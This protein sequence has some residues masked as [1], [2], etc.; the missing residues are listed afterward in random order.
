MKKT[1]LLVVSLL[2]VTWLQAQVTQTANV[3]TAGTLSTVASGYLTTVTNLTVTGTIDAR[4]FKTMRDEMTA[5]TE[6]DL[7]SVAIEE[8][9]GADGTVGEVTAYQANEIPAKALESKSGLTSFIFPSSITSIGSNSFY[10]CS[11]LAM[12]LII[13]TSV[14][15]I[16]DAAFSSC[17]TLRGNLTLPPNLASLGSDAFYYCLGLCG[18]LT[19][20][21]TL[22][23][24]NA[25]TFKYCFNLSGDLTLPSSITHIHDGAFQDCQRLTLASEI[26]PS[27]TYIGV[28]AFSNC[29][30]SFNVND[31]NPN[32]SSLDGIL[33]N[34][35]QTTLMQ[36]LV[37]KTGS[38]TIPSTVTIINPDAFRACSGLTGNL[39]IPST[40]TSIGEGAFYGCSGLTGT[41]SIPSTITS[42][43]K[44]AFRECS[45]FTGDLT[46]PSTVTSIGTWAFL[47]CSGLT[48]TLTIP[49][50]VQNIGWLAFS[51]CSGLT[52][53]HALSQVPIDMKYSGSVFGDIN[54]TSCIL[55]VPS[56]S[57]QAYEA[58]VKWSDFEN[59]VDA[60]PAV[61]QTTGATSLIASG[62][63]ANWNSV[64]YASKYFLDVA[65]DE[66]FTN[67]V[68][69]YDNLDVSDNVTA[70]VMGLTA[71]TAY[72]FRVRAQNPLGVSANSNVTMATLKSAQTI[73]FGALSEKTYGDAD[74]EL[75][76]SASSSLAISYS[77]SDT[78]VATIVSGR[79]HIV[80]AGTCTIY[81]NQA[82]DDN[83]DAA[84]QKSQTLTI[85]KATLTATADDNT[86]KAGEENPVFT[87]KLS[88]FV[89]GDDESDITELPKVSC[90]ADENSA[91]G[92]YPITVSGGSADNY[93]FTYA[94][95][96]LKVESTTAINS[97]DKIEFKV[98]PNPF[99]SRL[100]VSSSENIKRIVV[101]N[102]TG[103]PL[104]V[105]IQQNTNYEWV[106][107]TSSLEPGIYLVT[108]Y[109]VDGKGVVTKVVKE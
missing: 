85:T 49:A 29:K 61:P 71:G 24:I 59:I 99:T 77:S 44:D 73:T 87:V 6:I 70:N 21:S 64:S 18:S 53:I 107:N 94:E 20:P 36:C 48:G 47:G 76:A 45:G 51:G 50:S 65:T 42:I 60:V 30:G 7:S 58:A 101:T 32:Y 104:E 9:K 5:L 98:C 4:D 22:T 74:F 27:L 84:E 56:G 82:G 93:V 66:A 33:Y 43:N 91:L 96:T 105:L 92:D 80:G 108:L 8:Y 95:G 16:G 83:Y 15:K 17:I 46:I 88:G 109:S 38:L 25:R 89:L 14:T 39:S 100:V 12:E 52:E 72:Y 102:L 68:S 63:I 26:M 106:I 54:K 40:I 103:Q 86:K 57:K 10:D 62:F 78:D 35:D 11:N 37:S 79:I 75:S 90:T 1:I 2:L 13:P 69:G 34:K 31:G 28:R 97:T 67:M 41:L 81:A 23:V 3:T 19:L 55:Y